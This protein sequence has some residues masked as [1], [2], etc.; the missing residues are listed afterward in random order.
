MADDDNKQ[1]LLKEAYDRGILPPDM[2]SAYEEA[3]KRQLL[4]GEP[5]F[6]MEVFE[7]FTDAGRGLLEIG[8]QLMPK[9]DSPP[10][11]PSPQSGE[12]PPSG[13]KIPARPSDGM[14]T[15]R[16][17]GNALNPLN[18]IAPAAI[19]RLA[20]AAGPMAK[21]IGSGGVA[22]LLQPVEEPTKDFWS[23]KVTQ[24]AAGMTMGY[25]FSV[26]GKAASKG[27][28]ALGNWLVS[29]Y[30]ENIMS[31]AVATVMKR[32]EQDQKHGGLTAQNMI[33]LVDAANA[34]G[35]PMTLSDVGG[36]KLTGLAGNVYRGSGEGGA[37]AS[38]MWEQRD[39]AAAQRIA[40]DIE[41]YVHGG[42]SSFETTQALMK[43]RSAAAQPAYAELDKV[44][45]IWSPR[46]ARFLDEPDVKK[47]LGRGYHIERLSSLAEDRPFNA[48]MMGVDLDAEGNILFLKTPNMRVLDMG[49]QGLDAMIADERNEITGRLSNMGVALDKVRRSYL[50]EI[51]KLDT[52][53]VYRKARETWSGPS[54]SLDAIRAG[55]SV[56]ENSPEEN[57]AL[58]GNLKGNDAEFFRVGVSD[59]LK[60]KLAKTGFTGDEAK[61]I[62]KNQWMR[63]QMRPAFKT[64]EDFDRFVNSVATESKMFNKMRAI[65]GGSQTAER[66]AEEKSE[67][68]LLATG[69]AHVAKSLAGGHWMSAVRDMYRLHRDLGLRQDP[70]LNESIAKILF[71]P[72]SPE[73]QAAR[74]IL[75]PPP[76][77]SGN[78]LAGAADAMQDVVAPYGAAASGEAVK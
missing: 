55:R 23:K 45:G 33:D 14:T 50:A 18:Y 56:F 21:A 29:K 76:P 61:S 39:N 58:L 38:E 53:G 24:G 75:S 51:D 17:I 30:P 71:S 52:K 73:N 28:D 16:F 25:G 74:S 67:E 35:K 31:Q 8:E 69:G 32:I 10:S 12:K 47:G 36:K 57:A 70:K 62:I 15:G 22:G 13:E 34:A 19:G 65:G 37:I 4:P 2:R 46:L 41:K 7:G 5:G 1:A 59:I 64:P 66:L 77:T 49:K 43:G 63:D 27:L 20:P 6:A 9:G 54:S 40:K 48:K 26:G 60:E 11:A 72:T 3:Q 42:Q 44:Q 78:Y 68:N